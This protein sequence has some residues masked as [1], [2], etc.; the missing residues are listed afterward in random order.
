M[1]N[2]IF[3]IIILCIFGCG[4]DVTDPQAGY[5][6]KSTDNSV[7]IDNSIHYSET[8]KDTVIIKDT[9]EKKIVDTLKQIKIDT[10]VKH[11]VDTLKQIKV[12]TVKTVKIDTVK[13]VKV[14]TVKQTIID[15]VYEKI[16]DTVYTKVIDTLL[17]N[18]II[19]EN[20]VSEITEDTF[21][22]ERDGKSY[23][24][25]QI[26]GKTWFKENLNFKT[27][28]SYCYDNKESNCD[29]FGRLYTYKAAL[30]ACPAGFHLPNKVEIEEYANYYDITKDRYLAGAKNTNNEFFA[31]NNNLFLRTNE[32]ISTISSC[33]FQADF[34][35]KQKVLCGQYG[36]NNDAFSVRCIKD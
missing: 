30:N 36:N 8:I 35:G 19:K 13:I 11:K 2:I 6:D 16:T 21:Y 18:N 31:L 15:T 9:V 33:Y 25:E 32:D 12:D 5:F 17:M 27:N 20:I 1:K 26:N 34:N 29:E 28:E 23:K 22:D 3:T 10:V 14:D 7:N 4:V 24:L